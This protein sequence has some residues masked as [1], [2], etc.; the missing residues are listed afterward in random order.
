MNQKSRHMKNHKRAHHKIPRSIANPIKGPNR[1]IL[2]PYATLTKSC[3]DAQSLSVAHPETT[4]HGS[5]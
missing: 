4:I 5:L 2:L 1:I 3:A